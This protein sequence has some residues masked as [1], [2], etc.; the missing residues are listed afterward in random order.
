VRVNEI[1]REFRDRMDFYLVY[2]QEIHP[3]DGWQVPA[4]IN[5]GI[6]HTQPTTDDERAEMAGVCMLNL[7]F[8]MPLLLDN[9]ENEVDQKYAALPER[10]YVIDSEGLVAYRSDMGPWGFD[11]EAW[12][13]A[14]AEQVV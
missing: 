13:A 2:I 4:N 10:L 8:D 12:R 11:A 3:S 5:D 1:Y 7:K 14:I 6:L 9:M